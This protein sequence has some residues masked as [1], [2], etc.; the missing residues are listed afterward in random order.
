[1][2]SGHLSAIIV[3][4]LAAFT[5]GSAGAE[6]LVYKHQGI[7]RSAFL[8]RSNAPQSGSRPLVVALHGMNQSV[9]SL[10]TWLQLDATADR[11]GFITA[12]PAAVDL[13]WSY[14]RPI[15]QPMPAVNGDPVDD[16]G[17]LRRL[18]DDLVSKKIADPARIYVTGVSRGGLMAFTVACALAD[19]LAAVAPLIT[20]MTEFQVEDCRPSR[21]VPVMAIA[22]TDDRVQSFRGAKGLQGRL[23]SVPE[24]MNF[25]RMQHG[26][27]GRTGR[28]LPHRDADDPTRVILIE[29]AT[30]RSGTSPRIYRIVGGGH[31][32][33]S[34]A[35]RASPESERRFGLRNRDIETANEVWA[36]FEKYSR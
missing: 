24:T 29:W 16:I 35:A 18:I 4:G 8:Y 10:R 26:C 15:N 22:G 31:Q 7:E 12:Y 34:I 2:N 19:R 9:D 21:P 14:G 3:F 13:K 20:G 28:P 30:C 36:F 32:I 5:G 17:Y 11:A 33:P 23:L 27:T 25:W 6:M 1:M